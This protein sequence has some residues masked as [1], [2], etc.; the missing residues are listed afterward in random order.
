[1]GRLFIVL[2]LRH[3]DLKVG[4]MADACAWLG[5]CGCH[6]DAQCAEFSLHLELRDGEML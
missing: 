3:L 5:G 1:M 6:A 2:D 4:E